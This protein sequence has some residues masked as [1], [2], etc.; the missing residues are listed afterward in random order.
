MNAL[1]GLVLAVCVTFALSESPEHGDQAPQTPPADPRVEHYEKAM[2][3]RS[4]HD[5]SWKQQA[6]AVDLLVAASG[7]RLTP[8]FLD[9]LASKRAWTSP[10]EEGATEL[11]SCMAGV[12]LAPDPVPGA[13]RELA[14]AFR[15]G[16]G[17]DRHARLATCLFAR[18]ADLGDPE[19][20]GQMGMRYAFGLH[21]A[22]AWDR[23]GIV[24]FG[25]PDEELAMLHY[26]LGATGDDAY[27]RMALAARHAHGIGVPQSC[28]TAAVYYQQVAE[29]VASLS[30]RANA[31][32]MID[33]VKLAVQVHSKTD[34]QREVLQFY[35][36]SADKGNV[37]AQAAVGQVLN[38]GSHG[39]DRDHS[40]ALHY[41]QKA[42]AAG[43]I[44]ATAHLGH[45]HANGHGTPKDFAAA[46]KWLQKAADANSPSGQ[47][48]LG[49]MYL[50]GLDVEEDAEA[51]FKLLSQAANQGSA[52]ANFYLGVMHQHGMGARKKNPSKAFHHFTM[53]S[54]GG[55][56][57]GMYNAAM[58]QLGGKGT[59]QACKPALSLLKQL[60]E[61]GPD[62]AALQ[63]ANE[64][65][66]SGNYPA[67]LTQYLQAAEMGI[68]AAQSNAAFILHRGYA[69]T[70][71][72]TPNVTFALLRRS[73]E[74]ANVQSSLMVAD[75]Y[76][77]G[78]GVEQDWVRASA[79]YYEAYLDRSPH[80][81]WNLGY[82]HEFGIGVPKDLAV[83]RRFYK[84]ARHTSKDATVAVH[85]ATAWLAVHEWW[86]SAL[87]YVPASLAGVW[88]AALTV[89]PPHT[90]VM[91]AYGDALGAL[92]PTR[93]LVRA[94]A[95]VGSMFAALRLPE[96]LE[97]LLDDGD[98][99]GSGGDGGGGGDG[100]GGSGSAGGGSGFG[101]ADTTLLLGLVATLI[102]VLRA[103]QQR[104]AARGGAP[105]AAGPA[106]VLPVPE[107]VPEVE[108]PA[109]EG[110]SNDSAR[111]AAVAAA[112]QRAS[113]GG[114]RGSPDDVQADGSAR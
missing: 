94:E 22:D 111:V 12:W 77:Y 82:A 69:L 89:Q 60:A 83:A 43:D 37:D 6:E 62:A 96:L 35:Q 106:P 2:R 79:V 92:M 9:L 47:F 3:M 55:H 23:D 13:V 40:A 75:A 21:S 59:A 50:N 18:A 101:G 14:K 70:R 86:D 95:I 30:T 54:H 114:G 112:Q 73:S 10:P 8:S 66:F 27:S 68:E 31:L 76:M 58:M 1:L 90:T 15:D 78:E 24:A 80:A 109:G 20:Q 36:Y 26:Y 29:Q 64:A 81:M 46:R 34:K 61:R 67:S 56:A 25:E 93:A 52:D 32:P 48:G 45:M 42:A 88:A 19:A 57:L 105:A 63:N 108:E 41:L 44:E 38:Y 53:A 100:E 102:V 98:D 4:R 97:S 28:W 113:S 16:E 84:M 7:L 17:A 110:G 103:R 72:L 71:G 51:G 11:V 74:Q 5:D 91:G 87:P 99:D 39:V 49:Y 33:R 107:P 104:A 85:V 65:F